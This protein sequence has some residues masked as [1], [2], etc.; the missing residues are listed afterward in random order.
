MKKI[1]KILRNQ[2]VDSTDQ[3]LINTLRRE[4]QKERL[5]DIQNSEFDDR[6]NSQTSSIRSFQPKERKKYFQ[7]K[8]IYVF[9]CT[10]IML[11][12]FLL[13]SPSKF[14]LLIPGER[15]KFEKKMLVLYEIKETKDEFEKSLNALGENLNQSFRLQDKI[16]WTGNFPAYHALLSLADIKNEFIQV[17]PMDILPKTQNTDFEFLYRRELNLIKETFL[18]QDKDT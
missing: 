2:A 8:W 11:L 1:L 15:E 13:P 6:L 4:A 5:K 10:C 17:S 14:K 18:N 12:W 9:G 7:P 16:E 3:N